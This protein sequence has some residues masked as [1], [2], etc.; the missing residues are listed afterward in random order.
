[1]TD[2]WGGVG[3]GDLAYS[4]DEITSLQGQV[5]RVGNT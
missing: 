2:I 3:G 4:I 5:G 1:M